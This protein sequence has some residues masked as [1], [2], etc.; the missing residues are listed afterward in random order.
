MCRLWPNYFAKQMSSPS[1]IEFFSVNRFLFDMLRCEATSTFDDLAKSLRMTKYKLS[2]NLKDWNRLFFPTSRSV[3][4]QVWKST[5]SS[6]P[7]ELLH[8]PPLAYQLFSRSIGSDTFLSFLDMELILKAFIPKTPYHFD[9]QELLISRIDP[10][11][12]KQKLNCIERFLNAPND[13]NWTIQ[14]LSSQYLK[15]CYDRLPACIKNLTGDERFLI[16]NELSVAFLYG[17]IT[18]PKGG[19]ASPHLNG[20][21]SFASR[22]PGTGYLS[23]DKLLREKNK[24]PK[25]KIQEILTWLQNN[26]PLYRDFVPLTY[27]N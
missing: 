15:C 22:K 20:C 19:I 9:H 27:E 16:N 1:I 21:F 25:E 6:I 14:P 24:I 8:N 23:L 26:N 4:F 12:S 11:L 3:S 17:V 5:A 18:M 2:S 10:I 7:P 13:V